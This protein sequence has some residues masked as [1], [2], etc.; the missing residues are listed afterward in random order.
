VSRKS[1]RISPSN[2]LYLEVLLASY[3]TVVNP[4]IL[5]GTE[6]TPMESRQMRPKVTSE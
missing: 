5:D 3:S 4:S 6:Q 2:T 1:V